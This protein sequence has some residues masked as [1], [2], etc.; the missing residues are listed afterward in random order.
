MR[1]ALLVAALVGALVVP[2]ARAWRPPTLQEYRLVVKGLPAFYHQSCIRYSIRIS[3]VDRRFAAVFFRFVRGRAPCRPFGGQ[4]LMK[5]LTPTRWVKIGEG[6]SWPCRVT[7]VTT[8]VVR[9]LFG[10]CAL[11]RAM[12]SP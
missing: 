3:T 12:P 5:R 9:D 11:R 6:S 7:G 2:T 10:E 1:R 4:V 8:G